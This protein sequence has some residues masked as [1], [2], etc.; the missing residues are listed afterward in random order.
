ME[1][2]EKGKKIFECS[3]CGCKFTLDKNDT[4]H[5][6]NGVYSNWDYF[7]G[8]YKSKDYDYVLCPQCGQRVKV[9]GEGHIK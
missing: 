8:D 9:A 3:V 1:I 6:Y 4:I 5:H 2:I 7:L